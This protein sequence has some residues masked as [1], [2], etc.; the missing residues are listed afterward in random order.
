MIKGIY[1]V[2][3]VV[4]NA[5]RSS[6]WYT[7]KLGFKVVES[8]G[9]WITVAPKSAKKGASLIHLCEGKLEPGNTG[10]GMWADDID[11]TYKQLSKNGVAFTQKPI[12]K[13]WGKYAMFKDPDRNVFWLFEG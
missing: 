7:S 2:A 9:H 8:M 12:D 3:V 5:K 13:G 11:K 6:K 1:D 4:S 10:I